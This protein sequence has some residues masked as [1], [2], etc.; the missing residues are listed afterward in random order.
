LLLLQPA[1]Y[2]PGVYMVDAVSVAWVVGVVDVVSGCGEC[3]SK[4]DKSSKRDRSSKSGYKEAMKY[5]HVPC[6]A[7]LCTQ[8]TTAYTQYTIAYT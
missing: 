7:P 3:A 5:M 1:L 4:R 2:S 6:D 8:Y